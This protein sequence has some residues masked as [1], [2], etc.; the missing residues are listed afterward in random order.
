MADPRAGLEMCCQ[1][2]LESPDFNVHLGG[3]LT[4]IASES[5]LNRNSE[6]G[7]PIVRALEEHSCSTGYKRNHVEL[8]AGDFE[9]VQNRD[10]G[11][12][13]TEPWDFVA[14]SGPPSAPAPSNRGEPLQLGEGMKLAH[15][16]LREQAMDPPLAGGVERRVPGKQL[17][18][19]HKFSRGSL[20]PRPRRG[21]RS[22]I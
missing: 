20:R 5:V 14:D 18:I 11:A 15:A 6:E 13:I 19:P 8:N 17:E 2:V 12:D 7:A 21:Q 10:R 3:N 16:E 1:R 22:S 4:Q 9:S